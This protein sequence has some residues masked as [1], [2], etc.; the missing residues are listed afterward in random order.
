MIP[1]SPMQSNLAF[2]IY[3]IGKF[4]EPIYSNWQMMDVLNNQSDGYP[5]LI[6]VNI[7]PKKSRKPNLTAGIVHRHSSQKKTKHVEKVDSR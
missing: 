5:E 7:P 6:F 4:Y 2:E 1:V 3:S